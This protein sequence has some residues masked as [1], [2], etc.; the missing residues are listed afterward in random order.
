ML[1]ATSSITGIHQHVFSNAHQHDAKG[2]I[3]THSVHDHGNF[4]KS[5]PS[6][7][8][9]GK[10]FFYEIVFLLFYYQPN[11]AIRK[12]FHIN[13]QKNHSAYLGIISVYGKSPLTPPPDQSHIQVNNHK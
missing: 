10:E 1:H 6:F 4:F 11:Y 13:S 2:H 7:T 3:H 8:E 12:T 9:E 5:L